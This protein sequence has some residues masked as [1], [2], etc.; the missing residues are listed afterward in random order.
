MEIMS[1]KL[2]IMSSEIINVLYHK[3]NSLKSVLRTIM[4]ILLQL[5][6]E[7]QTEK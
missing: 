4:Y 5:T 2:G 3:S 7:K 6:M 1:L